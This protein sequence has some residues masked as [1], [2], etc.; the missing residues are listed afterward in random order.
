MGATGRVGAAQVT[1]C[2]CPNFHTRRRRPR[3]VGQWCRRPPSSCAGRRVHGPSCHADISAAQRH[4]VLDQFSYFPVFIVIILLYFPHMMLQLTFLRRPCHLAL[5]CPP[6]LARLLPTP[7]PHSARSV[8]ETVDT[9]IDHAQHAA[10]SCLL[11]SPLQVV[12]YVWRTRSLEKAGMACAVPAQVDIHVY[13]FAISCRC[14]SH[15]YQ[16]RAHTSRLL[17]NE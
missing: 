6:T 13:I 17:S 8:Q 14:F 1:G 16:E 9:Q 3:A 15:T 5:D 10:A 7:P 4:T 12:Y 11:H 2:D